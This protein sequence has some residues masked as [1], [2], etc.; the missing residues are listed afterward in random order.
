[1]HN[2]IAPGFGPSNGPGTPLSALYQ[3]DVLCSQDN[4][5][6][7]LEPNGRVVRDVV[8]ARED[9]DHIPTHTA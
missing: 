5:A 8:G 3:I 9:A 2:L 6:W 4:I 7:R 1:M